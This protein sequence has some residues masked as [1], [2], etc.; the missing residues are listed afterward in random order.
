[1]ILLCRLPATPLLSRYLAYALVAL[2][3]STIAIQSVALAQDSTVSKRQGQQGNLVVES[4]SFP[5]Q[6][7]GMARAWTNRY[8]AGLG[9][10]VRY[11]AA[12]ESAWADVYIYDRQMDLS[13]GSGSDHAANEIALALREINQMVARG[14]YRGAKV[15]ERGAELGFEKAYVSID[16]KDLPGRTSRRTDSFIFVAVHRGKFVKIR[17]SVPQGPNSASIAKSFLKA[18]SRTLGV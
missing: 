18:Y 3:L 1:M 6:I 4:F 16:A 17:L 2:A 7:V 15:V 12:E 8:G 10:S 11:M 14:I 9:F 13:R 5:P